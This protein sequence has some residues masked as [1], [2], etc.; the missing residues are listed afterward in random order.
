MN[1]QKKK[2][3]E[4]T[5]KPVSISHKTVV[6]IKNPASPRHQLLSL[7]SSASSL[8]CL[9]H[10]CHEFLFS[11]QNPFLCDDSDLFTAKAQALNSSWVH[12][13]YLM[14]MREAFGDLSESVSA[15][16]NRKCDCRDMSF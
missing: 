16:M 4:K 1:K 10:F 3:K 6:L 7:T 11:R 14:E 2:K 12:I 15:K 13:K 8:N 9:F 5:V